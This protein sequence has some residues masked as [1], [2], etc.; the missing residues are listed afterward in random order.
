MNVY[1]GGMWYRCRSYSS[2]RSGPLSPSTLFRLL[3]RPCSSS[4][5][6]SVAWAGAP[7]PLA[8][9][10]TTGLSLGPRRPRVEGCVAVGGCRLPYSP[11]RCEVRIDFSK[12]AGQC[13][14]ALQPFP[15][16]ILCQP[17][18]VPGPRPSVV[19]GWRDVCVLLT[20]RACASNRA[21]HLGM[22]VLHFAFGGAVPAG[23]VSANFLAV[24][25]SAVR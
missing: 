25:H 15:S 21:L 5:A 23:R 1:C 14:A 24:G 16:F 13:P 10:M 22:H 2:A 12:T 8:T 7:R 9:S 6:S 19:A 18:S 20:S 4:L 3:S 17:P 11:C